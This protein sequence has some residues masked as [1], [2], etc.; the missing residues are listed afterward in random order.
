[1]ARKIE[2]E[3]MEKVSPTVPAPQETPEDAPAKNGKRKVVVINVPKR[4]KL[5]YTPTRIIRIFLLLALIVVLFLLSY[6]FLE[7]RFYITKDLTATPKISEAYDV[8]ATQEDIDKAEAELRTALE[9]LV[10]APKE[11]EESADDSSAQDSQNSQEPSAESTAEESSTATTAKSGFLEMNTLDYNW[12]YTIQEG[13]N[14]EKLTTLID[15]V[16]KIKRPLYTQESLDRLNAA[17][18]KAQK[19]LC[20]SVFVS[21]NALQM[22]LGGTIGEA[23]GGNISLSNTFLRAIL[24]FA[25]GVLPMIAFLACLLDRRRMIKNIIVMICSALALADIFLTIYPYVGIGAVLTIIMYVLIMLLNIGGFYA[26]QQEKYIVNHPEMEAEYTQKHPQLVKALIN[27]KS[28]YGSAV[29]PR[30]EQERTAAVNA[31][32]RQAKK[33]KGR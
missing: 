12:M 32:K 13:V 6:P 8:L 15:E 33:K 10:E 5:L 14:E 29:P 17:V 31:K 16:K 23:F 19:I 27:H 21:Q 26:G 22:M 7:V 9:G 28:I 24:T 11:E 3:E 30:A 2:N 18:L 1:M 4:K 25:L 20:A